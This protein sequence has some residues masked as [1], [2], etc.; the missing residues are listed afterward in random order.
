M[1]LRFRKI[2]PL[3]SLFRISLSKSGLSLG[4]GPR[5]MNV[6]IGPRGIRRTV[7]LPGTG[8]SYQDTQ[9]WNPGIPQAAHTQPSVPT[10]T[11][12]P[13]LKIFGAVMVM[14]ILINV[15]VGLM[16]ESPKKADA[17]ANVPNIQPSPAAVSSDVP[18]QG[19][20]LSRE[21]VRELQGILKRQGFNPG[22]A[23]GLIGPQ[24]TLAARA[25]AKQFI[26]HSSGSIDSNLLD[27]ARTLS[28]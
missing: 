23:D 16:G 5:G 3:G 8:L 27:K 19:H 18:A 20:P 22:Q 1:G 2:I 11:G 17:P 14:A 28:R 13:W 9:S 7:G 25:F 24:T 4:I 12:I 10:G 15:L 21:E 6:N 26:P